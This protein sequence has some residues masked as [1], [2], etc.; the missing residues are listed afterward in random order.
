MKALAAGLCGRQLGV[1][2]HAPD[3]EN[4]GEQ[5][6]CWHHEKGIFGD[7]IHVADHDLPHGQTPI[8]Q[9][10][11]HV[12][13]VEKDRDQRKAERS[14]H[15]EP[16]PGAE[17]IAVELAETVHRQVAVEAVHSFRDQLPDHR[18][19]ILRSRPAR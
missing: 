6:R 15:E 2:A 4:G 12:R 18:K 11:Q 14:H 9:L 3:G 19:T 8:Q 17:D 7:G 16:E 5:D 1:A 13:E 10:A